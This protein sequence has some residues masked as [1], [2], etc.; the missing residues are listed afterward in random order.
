MNDK[1]LQQHYEDFYED[2]FWEMNDKYGAV[3]EMNV[4]D[5]LGDHLIGN[6]YIMFKSE[7]AAERAA[8]DLCNRWFAGTYE[9][10]NMNFFFIFSYSND[11]KVFSGRPLFAELSPV[12]DFREACCRFVSLLVDGC[13]SV[14]N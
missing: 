4:C 2:I 11:T 12:T 6:V 7:E 9:T 14:F 1:E 8:N 10:D 5:N 3:E 13:R